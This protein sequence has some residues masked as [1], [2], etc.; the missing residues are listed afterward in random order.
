MRL[1]IR[2]RLTLWN[3]LALALLLACFAALVYGLLRHALIEQTDRSLRAG[4]GLLRG[5]AEADAAPGN[6]L[7]PS[8]ASSGPNVP[9]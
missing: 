5:D 3:T 2:W 7:Y 8:V 6:S 4:F 1:S 9:Q